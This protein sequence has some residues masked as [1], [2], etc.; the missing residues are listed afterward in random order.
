MCQAGSGPG[1]SAMDEPESL[2]WRGVPTS[3]G[4]RNEK[5]MGKRNRNRSRA[6]QR[7]NHFFLKPMGKALLKRHHLHW[8][9]KMNRVVDDA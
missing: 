8:T 3:R 6:E 9:W 4:D 2:P 5:S 1:E 7:H